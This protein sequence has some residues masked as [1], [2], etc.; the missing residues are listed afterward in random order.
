[1]IYS[2]SFNVILYVGALHRLTY[3]LCL[4][5]QQS[6]F[7]KDVLKLGKTI[8]IKYQELKKEPLVTTGDYECWQQGINV[9][10]SFS[11]T[12]YVKMKQIKQYSIKKTTTNE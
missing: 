11:V 7:I 1:M 10:L 2:R 5:Q 4:I 3:Y 6:S 8:T 9:F 12:F